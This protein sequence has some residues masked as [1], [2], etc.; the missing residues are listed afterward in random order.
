MSIEIITGASSG[1]GSELTKQLENY[2]EGIDEIWAIA[3]R[4]N[5]LEDLKTK[6]KI[7]LK[8]IALDLTDLK[9]IETLEQMLKVSG[10]EVGVLINCAGYGKFGSYAD[11][12]NSAAL[13]MIDLNC[14]AL[15]G[16]TNIALPFMKRGAK[17]LQICSISSFQ[18][19]PL[20]SVY[21]ASKVFVL[22]YS[23]ALW[24]ELKPRGITVT[25]L[26]PGWVDTAFFKTAT[27]TKNPKAVTKYT[28]MQT[29]ERVVKQGLRAM[30][31]GRML[32]IVGK[33]NKILYVLNKILPVKLVMKT[34][35]KTQK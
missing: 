2:A 14:R 11:I 21:A 7:P 26:C 18:P 29:P 34:W 30:Q 5:L 35:L 33:Q 25:A 6:T 31:K 3:R 15:V 16:I 8:P 22:N 20:M 24:T 12:E 17:I 32:S 23:R 27:D 10:K 9:S 4:E 28:F 19:L 13:G 1:I